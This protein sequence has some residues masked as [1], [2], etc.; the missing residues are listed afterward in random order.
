MPFRGHSVTETRDFSEFKVPMLPIPERVE[1]AI[2][3]GVLKDRELP[4]SHAGRL[5]DLEADGAVDEVVR[6][7]DGVLV[8]CCKT[9]MP[10]V[11]PEMWDWWFGWHGL[12]SERYKLW[13]PKDHIGSTMAENRSHVKDSRARYIGNT[14]FVD[15]N[16]AT[17]EVHRLSV[18]FKAPRELGLDEQKLASIGTAICARGGFRRRFADTAYLIH[19]VRRTATGSEMLSRFWLGHVQSKIPVIGSMITRRMNT[20]SVRTGLITDEF[21]LSLLR[22]CSE[23]MGHLARI[24]PSL[25]ARFRND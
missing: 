12:S 1:A 14:S 19:F 9:E 8:V 23:E 16:I 13:H 10:N 4:F 2:A 15:E 18:A 21:G 20:A 17:S 5:L 24:L 11:T 6:N 22:H 25:Y 7:G 3:R